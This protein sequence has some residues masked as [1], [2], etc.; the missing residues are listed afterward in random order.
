[1]IFIHYKEVKSYSTFY[2]QR[3]K[4]MTKTLK[5]I[6]AMILFMSLFLFAMKSPIKCEEDAD[7]PKSEN[8]IYGYKCVNFICE[9]TQLI[10]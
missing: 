6:Y 3:G 10:L 8:L 5:L 9:W 2:M 7:C 1:M 4:D